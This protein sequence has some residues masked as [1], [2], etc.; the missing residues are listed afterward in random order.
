[1]SNNIRAFI[2]YSHDSRDHE[3][4]VLALSE[5]LRKDGIE[6][7]VDQYVNGTPPEGWARWM[8]D[9]LDEAEF[10]LLV[11]TETYYRRFRGHEQPGKGKGADWEG[12]L[13]TQA[14]YDAR[15]RTVKFV[16]ILF[17]SDD[18]RYIPEP[19]R[20]ATCYTMNSE[21]TYEGLYDFL[22]GQAGMEPGP[23]GNVRRKERQSA[24]ALR[25]ETLSE[26]PAELQA[27]VPQTSETR[28]TSQPTQLLP[29]R[30]AALERWQEKLD[31]LLLEEA[32]AADANQRFS[33]R[34]SIEE[35]R[36]K[37]R[38]LNG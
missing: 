21:T 23:L 11:C 4:R 35:A 28:Q 15:S 2:S 38:E 14:I 13:I 34:K 30:N 19:L 31:F 10:V 1:M 18:E 24:E 37:I 22:L 6:A 16:P 25:F 32:S 5:R 12:A 36:K 20:S 7:Q 8:L 9:Q 27:S 26:H 17:D 33:I 29:S 3:K